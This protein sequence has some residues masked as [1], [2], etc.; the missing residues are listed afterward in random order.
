M[1]KVYFVQKTDYAWQIESE[2]GKIVQKDITCASVFKAE[3][4]I[5][6]YISSFI[7]WT[8]ELKLLTPSEGISRSESGNYISTRKFKT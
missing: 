2:S 8:Y 5:K 1:L 4:Y 3:E 6:A 7:N